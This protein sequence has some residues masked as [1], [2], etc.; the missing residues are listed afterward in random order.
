MLRR[1]YV[2]T[3][4]TL[5][6]TPP[7]VEDDVTCAILE[8][9]LGKCEFSTF[10]AGSEARFPVAPNPTWPG[11]FSVYGQ[12]SD[13]LAPGEKTMSPVALLYGPP[14]NAR[15]FG[16]AG[17]EA[18]QAESVA[19]SLRDEINRLEGAELTAPVSLAVTLASAALHESMRSVAKTQP[20][21]FI[22]IGDGHGVA[23]ESMLSFFAGKGSNVSGYS[24]QAAFYMGG[25]AVSSERWTNSYTYGVP[26]D[27]VRNKQLGVD[28]EHLPC[29][30][31]ECW[32]FDQWMGFVPWTADMPHAGPSRWP[33]GLPNP[34]NMAADAPTEPQLG[35][36]QR[37]LGSAKD[38]SQRASEWLKSNRKEEQRLSPSFYH[39]KGAASLLLFQMAVELAPE[40]HGFGLNYTQLTRDNIE[41]AMHAMNGSQGVETFWG[42]ISIQP[43]EGWNH[44]FKG[45]S[46]GQFRDNHTYPSLV[47]YAGQS[48]NLTIDAKYPAV[49][50]DWCLV[51]G[52]RFNPFDECPITYLHKN[53]IIL[54]SV[55]MLSLVLGLVFCC[56]TYLRRRHSR[57]AES[58]R[59]MRRSLLGSTELPNTQLTALDVASR[60]A[61]SRV[62]A[63]ANAPLFP[64]TTAG[65]T[66]PG[67]KSAKTNS[68][69][70]A[71]A[72]SGGIGSSARKYSGLT[73]QTLVPVMFSDSHVR[74]LQPPDWRQ[75]PKNRLGKGTYGTVYRA[76][77]RGVK[78]AVK[79]IELPNKPQNERDTALEAHK[80]KLQKIT[81]DFV[82]EVDVGCELL[83]PNL[84]QML[85]YATEPVL[86]IIQELM[87]G[88]SLD[89][90]L[91]VEHWRPNVIQLYKGALDVAQ[92][93]E[94][95]HTHFER[96]AKGRDSKVTLP[97]IHRDLKSPN[98]LLDRS[99]PMSANDGDWSV[100][101]KVSDF[102][103]S[104]DKQLDT[105]DDKT[106][107]MSG[108]GSVL[109]MAPEML[110][111]DHYNESV[112]VY[113][114]AMV[115][116]ELSH[117]TM[118]W[119]DTGSRPHEVP[120]RVTRDERPLSQL[121]E[122]P[123]ELQQLIKDCWHKYAIDCQTARPIRTRTL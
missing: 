57:Y 44:F 123:E 110:R 17:A 27:I 78:I 98:I 25:L 83:H 18:N 42:P 23:F 70:I 104:R 86:V 76:E 8:L 35:M 99:P 67:S 66:T 85:G 16:I 93:M 69:Q 92:A 52:Q 112:D 100:E 74:E 64:S 32:S 51:N 114:Y 97:V 54:W 111:G 89:K 53:Q 65:S 9:S 56:C 109:W 103:L 40:G 108:V 90:Q 105:L 117:C 61:T 121:R 21:V 115:L 29:K 107:L 20:D 102:G 113:S 59:G 2:A 13:L 80:K 39:A 46:I 15:T 48:T 34:Y 41:T 79:A 38:F 87:A 3:K 84:V 96:G 88:G 60:W 58:S 94:H 14:Y 120:H 12:E 122:A 75:I 47:H 24:P 62:A 31:R 118:P 63:Q 1:A 4:P 11:V 26:E 81:R 82:K 19:G 10:M 68:F 37:Y 91:Y 73:Q 5:Y 71:S 116:V 28:S 101:F 77:W 106:G 72:G 33:P 43:N 55:V 22:G 50:P 6:L 36:R 95:L 45:M 119:Q 30:G 7:D 49:W